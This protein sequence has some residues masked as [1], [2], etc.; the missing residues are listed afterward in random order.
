MLETH[1]IERLSTKKKDATSE[2]QTLHTEWEID[3]C[4]MRIE[5]KE[6]C[7]LIS[8]R[9]RSSFPARTTRSRIARSQTDEDR[10]DATCAVPA[11]ATES[12]VV[13]LVVV[14]VVV[15]EAVVLV[16]VVFVVGIIMLVSAVMLVLVVLV[17]GVVLFVLL[18]QLLKLLVLL[19]LLL[20]LVVLLL[21]V[22][23]V[24]V[25]VMAILGRME[26]KEE[27]CRRS[28]ASAS[29]RRG[30]CLD[31]STS[32]RPTDKRTP[33]SSLFCPHSYAKVMSAAINRA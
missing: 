12:P 24:V 30:M 16:V 20:L 32:R 26:A 10:S 15:V 18:L 6:E 7:Y 13:V 8:V 3:T 27:E 22:V 11:L 17:A 25:V 21:V 33:L 19:L 1:A 23:V 5:Y 9:L 28:M 4:W 2:L 31:N 29:D 14:V